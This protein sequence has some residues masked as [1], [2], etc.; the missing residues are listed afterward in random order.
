MLKLLFL[1]LTTVSYAKT[2]HCRIITY[3]QLV[4]IEPSIYDHRKIVKETT[5]PSETME[6]FTSLIN[7]ASG[8]LKVY[9]S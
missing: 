4:I 8:N 6:R 9:I 3:P 7:N 1:L 2:E 5:C